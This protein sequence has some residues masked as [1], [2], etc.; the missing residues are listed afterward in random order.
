[1]LQALFRKK[2]RARETKFPL[3]DFEGYWVDRHRRLEGRL[4]AVGD[5]GAAEE[6]NAAR[7]ARKKRR[8]VDLLRQMDL[9]DLRGKRVI[10]AGC[11]TGQLSELFFAL[12][13]DVVG[14][15]VSEIAIDAARAKCP[16]GQF[17]VGPLNTVVFPQ[18]ADVVFCVD[19]LYHI[20]D[21]EKWRAALANLA[22]VAS[23]TI[24]IVDQLKNETIKP[25]AHVHYRTRIMYDQIF[26]SLGFEEVKPG[27]HESYF[28]VFRSLN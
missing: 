7:Y 24:V 18:S 22:R 1:M 2:S 21:D 6:D 17:V 11:G 9:L 23:D 26:K 4:A 16:Q 25:A 27:V 20:V 10:D 3:T 28:L 12:G 5:I 8:I 13:A 15:D 14:A 19:V